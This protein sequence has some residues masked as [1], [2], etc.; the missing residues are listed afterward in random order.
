MTETKKKLAVLLSGRGSNMAAIL[1]HTR[2]GELAGLAEVALVVSNCPDAKGLET[3]AAAGVP[4]AVVPTRRPRAA[5]ERELI[6]AI[7]PYSPDLIVLA[8]FMRLLSP[9][10]VGHYR[11][12]ILNIHPADT[13]SHQGLDGYGWAFAQG[14]SETLIT[15]HRVDEGLDTGPIVGQAR[16]DLRGAASLAEVEQRGLRVEHQFYSAMIRRALLAED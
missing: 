1:Q 15:V 4:T 10:F 9:V 3:A 5:F 16:V 12:R 2:D 11:H 13:R 7:E 14:L 6:A 8:G